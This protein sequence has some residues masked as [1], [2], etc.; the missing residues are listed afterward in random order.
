MSSLSSSSSEA[1][2]LVEGLAMGEA[3]GLG[4]GEKAELT[5]GRAGEAVD[6]GTGGR[7]P[8]N[9]PAGLADG[10]AGRPPGNAEPGLE[11][12]GESGGLLPAEGMPGEGVEGLTPPAPCKGDEGDGEKA[13]L[14]PGAVGVVGLEPGVEGLTP[15]VVVAGAVDGA[16]DGLN[17]VGD[18]RAGLTGEPGITAGV[19]EGVAGFSLVT[20][21]GMTAGPPRRSGLAA[22]DAERVGS[23]D[24]TIPSSRVTA[25]LPGAPGM[26]NSNL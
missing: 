11:G 23:G 24:M 7:L 19:D 1:K 22:G 6:D 15:G 18:E 14:A 10:R 9:A 2:G 4:E 8:G 5:G 26:G 21:P 25:S 12:E 3:E 20:V 16:L 17:A 13:G